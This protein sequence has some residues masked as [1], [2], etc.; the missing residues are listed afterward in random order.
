MLDEMRLIVIRHDLHAFWQRLL[1]FADSALD[2]LHHLH[3]VGIRLL[4]HQGDDR[5][6]ATLAG[7]AAL[8]RRTLFDTRDI[9]QVDRHAVTRRHHCHLDVF[10]RVEAAQATDGIL[11]DAGADEAPRR[12][13]VAAFYRLFDI[14]E[15][16]V[17]GAQGVLIQGD[18]VLSQLAAHVEH[19]GDAGHV[20]QAI[21]NLPLGEFAQFRRRQISFDGELIHF[22]QAGGGTGEGWW[23]STR[24]QLAGHL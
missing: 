12:I 1:Q 17:I 18:P 19:F 22:G 20:E 15:S 21:A 4:D 11:G 14:L 6:F 3:R 10:H 13:L 7:D 24:R 23:L 16:D 9:P 2:A 5:L 8:N